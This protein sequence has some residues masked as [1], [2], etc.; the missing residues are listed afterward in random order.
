MNATT[1]EAATGIEAMQAQALAFWKERCIPDLEHESWRKINLAMF[2][3]NRFQPEKS[4]TRIEFEDNATI[5]DTLLFNEQPGADFLTL[6]QA[7]QDTDL[8]NLIVDDWQRE[9]AAAKIADNRFVFLNQAHFQKVRVLRLSGINRNPHVLEHQLESGDSLLHRTYIIV[10]ENSQA[11]LLEQFSGATQTSI[12]QSNTNAGATHQD[13]SQLILP[14]TR[15]IL[16]PNAHLRYAAQFNLQGHEWN[17]IN[18]HTSLMRDAHALTLVLPNGGMNGKA[19][20]SADV[21]ENGAEYRGLGIAIGNGRSFLDMEMLVRHLASHTSSS[22]LYKTV[23]KDRAHSIFNGNLFIPSGLK[24]V[25]SHQEN[26]NILLDKSA[27][28]Q[29]MPN[30]NIQSEQVAAEHG[31]TVGELDQQAMFFLM[32]RGLSYTN[33]RNIL[34]EAFITRVIQEIDWRDQSENLLAGILGRLSL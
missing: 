6:E 12:N 34:I 29:S 32:T 24:G 23:L 22:L 13:G 3:A 25:N 33:A 4:K 7:M 1:P 30:L 8:A 16:K 5:D 2:D 19:F 17:F 20:I 14:V 28:A 27:R 26:H 9:I 31:A 21:L 10:A 11:N 18:L 15:I